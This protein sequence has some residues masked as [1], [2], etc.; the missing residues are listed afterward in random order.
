MLEIRHR[1]AN[2][3]CGYVP[4]NTD[5]QLRGEESTE[6]REAAILIS[7]QVLPCQRR[8]N[9]DIVSHIPQESE[10]PVGKNTPNLN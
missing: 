1:I 9:L 3:I 8:K 7:W 2:E 4:I 6:F 5:C 10:F